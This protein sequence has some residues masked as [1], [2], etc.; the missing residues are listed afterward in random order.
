MAAERI[1]R[2][3]RPAFDIQAN[4][5]KAAPTKPVPA[6]ARIARSRVYAS[7]VVSFLVD[8]KSSTV[9]AAL[10]RRAPSC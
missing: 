5:T 2:R 7:M 4:T 6:V 9:H 10:L 3:N 8:D 1:E